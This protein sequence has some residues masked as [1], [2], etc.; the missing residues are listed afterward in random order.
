MSDQMIIPVAYLIKP[1]EIWGLKPILE[2]ISL[3]LLQ[4]N[5]HFQKRKWLFC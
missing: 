5:S 1:I 4:K 3:N 2:S